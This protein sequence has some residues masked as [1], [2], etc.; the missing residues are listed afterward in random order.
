MFLRRCYPSTRARCRPADVI[1]IECD[2]DRCASSLH[3]G[4][5]S[6]SMSRSRRLQPYPIN[7]K[8]SHRLARSFQCRTL[9]LVALIEG[10]GV[11]CIAIPFVDI[12]KWP[13][14]R[15]KVCLESRASGLLE[16]ASDCLYEHRIQHASTI[17]AMHVRA[18]VPKR[19]NSPN[20]LNH[21]YS[22]G[23]SSASWHCKALHVSAWLLRQ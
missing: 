6:S 23:L 16:T 18:S 9:P 1:P 13:E 19:C 11:S 2:V 21:F 4:A 5:A 22:R 14:Q 10:P 15:R 17:V 7:S 12:F 3:A 8:L 20:Y